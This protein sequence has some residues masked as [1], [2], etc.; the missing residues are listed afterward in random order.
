MVRFKDYKLSEP[1]IKTNQQL[2]VF[3]IDLKIMTRQNP[4]KDKVIKKTLS[5][6]EKEPNG[7][8]GCWHK[9]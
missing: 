6:L 2:K 8:N 1:I 4:K 7:Y 5:S 3:L 9:T